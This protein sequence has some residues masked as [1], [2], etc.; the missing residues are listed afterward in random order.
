MN[1]IFFNCHIVTLCALF[2]DDI[3][4]NRCNCKKNGFK[5]YGW[6]TL[7]DGTGDKFFAVEGGFKK[8]ANEQDDTVTLYAQWAKDISTCTA[9]VPNPIYHSGYTHNCFY[10][11]TWNSNHGGIMV[12]D[13]KTLLTYGTDYY[14]TMLE[15]LDGG[16]CE[17]LGERC[18]VILEGIG[19]YAGKLTAD[20]VIV[21]DTVI[22]R[23]W[24]DLTWSLD[25]D[26]KFTIIGSGTMKAAASYYEY[27][28][29]Q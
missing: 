5:E 2:S 9:N 15:S 7:A 26:G 19:A 16:Y 8:L 13:D 25:E 27:P 22:A 4:K 3:I 20:V 24:G 23:L 18:R 21:P 6:N 14:F 11:G 29:Y 12:Y 17:N 28:W 1:I 10:D